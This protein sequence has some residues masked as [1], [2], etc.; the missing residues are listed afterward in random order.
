ME[1]DGFSLD[2]KR[3]KVGDG[4]GDLPDIRRQWFAR[5]KAKTNDRKAKHFFVPLREIEANKFDLS[6]NRYS[7]TDYQEETFDPPL[8]IM[9]RLRSIDEE[10]RRDMDQLEMLFK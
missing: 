1:S 4:L 5:E 8:E 7:A 3:E 9:K 2:D 6:I 10:V